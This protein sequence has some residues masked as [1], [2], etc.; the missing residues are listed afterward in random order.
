MKS[1]LMRNLEFY[2]SC[3]RLD[4]DRYI[5]KTIYALLD[6]QSTQIKREEF[7]VDVN[8]ELLFSRRPKDRSF[9]VPNLISPSS[10]FVFH[11]GCDERDIVEKV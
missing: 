7:C 9:F 3:D 8:Q 5:R 4:H 6:K 2:G 1:L 10:I 11:I